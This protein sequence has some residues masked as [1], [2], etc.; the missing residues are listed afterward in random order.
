MTD[1]TTRREEI[2]GA[3]ADLPDSVKYN[4]LINIL[5][6]TKSLYINCTWFLFVFS[7][8]K[9]MYLCSTGDWYIASLL[10]L[11]SKL[12]NPSLTNGH[13]YSPKICGGVGNGVYWMQRTHLFQ[14]SANI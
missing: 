1:L 7:Q 8:L 9:L 10:D 13:G 14:T 3:E 2:D 6:C 5:S 12:G 4:L 11:H